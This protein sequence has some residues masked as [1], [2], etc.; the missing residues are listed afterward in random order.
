MSSL[1]EGISIRMSSSSHLQVV[2]VGVLGQSLLR[3]TA[4]NTLKYQCTE[5][6]FSVCLWNLP[7]LCVPV[8]PW[9]R[10]MWFTCWEIH[11]QA[12]AILTD[13]EFQS[14]SPV[15]NTM[16]VH[17]VLFHPSIPWGHQGGHSCSHY[18]VFWYM[19]TVHCFL[20]QQTPQK[21]AVLISEQKG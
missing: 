11:F 7:D 21:I 10:R 6:F 16:G 17:E 3:E 20:G 1:I 12:C 19:S 4:S 18:E 2:C 5:H 15:A 13:F 8:T 9:L 14:I